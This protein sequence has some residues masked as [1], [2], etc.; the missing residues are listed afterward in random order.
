MILDKIFTTES[1]KN[2]A[3]EHFQALKSNP[4]W[5]FLVEKLIK[6]DIA[7]I[8]EEILD[9]KKEWKEG[10]EKDQKRIRAYWIILSELPEKLIEALKTGQSDVFMD[11]DPYFKDTKEIEQSQQKKR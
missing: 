5:L 9:P 10:E 1:Q 2:E 7:K 4:D 6:S 8:T 11:Q 3:I